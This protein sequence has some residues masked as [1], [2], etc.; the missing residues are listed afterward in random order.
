MVPAGECPDRPGGFG[1]ARLAR[2]SGE[3]RKASDPVI[4]LYA[5]LEAVAPRTP[6][7]ILPLL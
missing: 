2:F 6:D 7:R 1:P 3:L 5:N 4:A